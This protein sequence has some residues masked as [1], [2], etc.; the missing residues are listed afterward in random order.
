MKTQTHVGIALL[1]ALFATE[2]ALAQITVNT[3]DRNAVV[4][5]F[6]TVY[7]PARNNS[8]HGWTGASSGCTAGTLNAQFVTDSLTTL[9]VFRAMAG[10]PSV[11][12]GN[13]RSFPTSGSGNVDCQQAA[14]M[15]HA[16]GTL[17]H[18]LPPSSSCWTSCGQCGAGHRQP[19]RRPRRARWH[20]A[21]DRRWQRRSRPPSLDA[22]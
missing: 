15:L 17:S 2:H 3:N 6:N 10:M 12:F 13:P 1:A 20:G 14:L 22:A 8:N 16:A 18:N 7:L 19:C 21:P 4:S 11:T 9:N 5:L